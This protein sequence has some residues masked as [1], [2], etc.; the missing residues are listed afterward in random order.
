[1]INQAFVYCKSNK[2][3]VYSTMSDNKNQP[4]T[5]GDW[6]RDKIKE[7]AISNAE[8]ARRVGV[9]PTYIGNLIRDF[10][11]NSKTGKIRASEPIIESIAKALNA[12][13][14]EARLAAGYA[15]I[16]EGESKDF[17]N[18]KVQLI[19]GQD[20]TDKQKEEFF[21]DVEIAIEIAKRRL[22]G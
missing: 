16:N 8:L 9:S 17:G 7:N 18:V 1:M 22:E 5:F 14:N 10:S 21:R 15:P 2:L 4:L 19:G 12:N 20:Y 3:F 6:L 13:L 11:P